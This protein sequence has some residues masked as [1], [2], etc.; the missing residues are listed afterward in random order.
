[1]TKPKTPAEAPAATAA[2]PVKVVS[3]DQFEVVDNTEASAAAAPATGTP[4]E[5]E[6]GEFKVV[7]YL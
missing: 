3:N 5:R 6:F 7:D 4:T 2:E 1:M